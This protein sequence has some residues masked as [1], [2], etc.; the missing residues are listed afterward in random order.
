M[1]CLLLL[2]VAHAAYAQPS[3]MPSVKEDCE[4][5]RAEQMREALQ[6]EDLSQRGKALSALPTCEEPPRPPPPPPT[7]ETIETSYRYQA[8]LADLG[9]VA[10]IAGGI[11]GNSGPVVDVGLLAYALGGPLVHGI[12]G[13]GGRAA[14]SLAIRVTL[15]V[16]N[17]LFF[18]ALAQ[19]SSSDDDEGVGLV[20]GGF[21]LGGI[22]AMIIDDTAIPHSTK[23]SRLRLVPTVS[24][25]PGG[26][27]LGLKGHF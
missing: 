21:L 13:E 14:A 10:L 5:R 26:M 7:T 19:Q 23:V 2:L 1:R 12:H 20:V 16:L 15:P 8:A 17:A 9:A 27:V 24:G 18:A 6:I 4:T 11:A 3:L 25:P 22:A